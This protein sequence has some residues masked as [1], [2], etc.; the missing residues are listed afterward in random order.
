NPFGNL[1]SR[2]QQDTVWSGPISVDENSLITIVS[3][4]IE[5]RTESFPF[6][7]LRQVRYAKS[8]FNRKV[9][10]HLPTVLSVELVVVITEVV[11]W[12]VS[13]LSE[14]DRLADEQVAVVVAGCVRL[15]P[16]SKHDVHVAVRLLAFIRLFDEG[17]KF[18]RVRILDLHEVVSDSEAIVPRRDRKTVGR[19]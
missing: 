17:A 14:F 2:R 19:V 13:A 16:L 10:T 5:Q 6:V 15:A 7:V 18:P 9:R 3:G 8:R 4:R 11:E 12:T 1:I